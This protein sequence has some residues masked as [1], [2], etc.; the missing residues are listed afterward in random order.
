MLEHC[1]KPVFFLSY[2]WFAY[3]GTRSLPAKFVDVHE[4][5]LVNLSDAFLVFVIPE[6]APRCSRLALV[7]TVVRG[8]PEGIVP[9][10][11][12]H[13]PESAFFRLSAVTAAAG[14]IAGARR[15]IEW[16]GFSELIFFVGEAFHPGVVLSELT[17]AVSCFGKKILHGKLLASSAAVGAAYFGGRG[18]G[19]VRRRRSRRPLRAAAGPTRRRWRLR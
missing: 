14:I 13:N 4:T 15:R 5:I 6:A 16:G 19:K 9:P 3:K 17:A 1:A 11:L 8:K 18:G 7:E 2:S 10:K 12:A